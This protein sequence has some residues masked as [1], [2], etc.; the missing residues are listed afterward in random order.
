[1]SHHRARQLRKLSTDAER[2]LWSALRSRRLD[3]YRFRRQ[4]QI[5]PY[6]ADFV[7]CGV[8]LVVEADG[9]QHTDEEQF[10]YD[11]RRTKYLET[12]GYRV[13]RFHNAVILC[14]PY[15]VLREIADA[16]QDLK[17]I[18]CHGGETNQDG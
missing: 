8:K 5:G 18:K 15:G 11:Y 4:H 1:M 7:C 3:G 9:S 14:A 2:R 16:L 13:L 10:W 6:Y 17:H 12:C